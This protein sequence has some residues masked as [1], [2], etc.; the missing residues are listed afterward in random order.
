MDNSL[1]VSQP[2]NMKTQ[3]HANPL[4]LNN[5]F[6]C[7]A[8]EWCVTHPRQSTY[9]VNYATFVITFHFHFNRLSISHRSSQA[10]C[11]RE[12]ITRVKSSEQIQ[13]IGSAA[14]ETTNLKTYQEQKGLVLE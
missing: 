1:C 6:R 8:V 11:Q 10:Q 7:F 5:P 4:L 9:T 12:R 14:M 13:R 2:V 3:T